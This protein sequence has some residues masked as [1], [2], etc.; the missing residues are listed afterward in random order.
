MTLVFVS[1]LQTRKFCLEEHILSVES[2]GLGLLSCPWSA[3]PSCLSDLGISGLSTCMVSPQDCTMPGSHEGL[4]LED[5]ALRAKG[6]GIQGL[7]FRYRL[8]FIVNPRKLEH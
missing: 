2:D 3:R 8:C 4:E 6:F 5:L 1:N 7:W